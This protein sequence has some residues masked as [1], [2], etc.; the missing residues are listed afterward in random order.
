MTESRNELR[1]RLKKLRSLQSDET[2]KNKSKVIADRLFSLQKF[3]ES[4]KALTKALSLL[5]TFI[6]DAKFKK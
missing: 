4:N 2:I 6:P 5:I 1:I 3:Q